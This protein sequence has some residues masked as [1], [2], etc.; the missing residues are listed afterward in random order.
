[1][2]NNT[3]SL[4]GLALIMLETHALLSVVVNDVLFILMMSFISNKNSVLAET[5]ISPADFGLVPPQF[6]FIHK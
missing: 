2:I 4:E 3:S 1:M 5:K 6:L